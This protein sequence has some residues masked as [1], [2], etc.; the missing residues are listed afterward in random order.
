MEF[1]NLPTAWC[2]NIQAAYLLSFALVNL[3]VISRQLQKPQL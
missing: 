3:T 2:Y 1:I